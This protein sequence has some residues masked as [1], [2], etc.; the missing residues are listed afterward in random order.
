MPNFFGESYHISQTAKFV[1]VFSLKS[2]LLLQYG[3][4][5]ITA[6]LKGFITQGL[7]YFAY[8]ANTHMHASG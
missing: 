7:T 3:T 8:S 5:F 4:I 6:L 1:K 2:F